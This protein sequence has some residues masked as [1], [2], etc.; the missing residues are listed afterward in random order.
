MLFYHSN[1]ETHV[2]LT[3]TQPN[4]TKQ[5]VIKNSFNFF[6]FPCGCCNNSIR[7]INLLNW[8]K[9]YSPNRIPFTIWKWLKK[10]CYVYYNLT[11]M[12]IILLK[13]TNFTSINY[14]FMISPN[15]IN[16]NSYNL[17][18]F[19]EAPQKRAQWS[20][21]QNHVGSIT[22]GETKFSWSKFVWK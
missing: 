5:Y 10:V 1:S 4:I 12:K 22:V 6:T 7:I 18:L 19:T 8:W 9:S 15:I 11:N 3:T 16:T 14:C 21:L 2:A 13:N 17:S 20:S